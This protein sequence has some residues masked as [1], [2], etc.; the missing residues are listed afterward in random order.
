[1]Q[2][3]PLKFKQHDSNEKNPQIW[4]PIRDLKFILLERFFEKSSNKWGFWFSWGWVSNL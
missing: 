1:M 2:Y 3:I 4:A